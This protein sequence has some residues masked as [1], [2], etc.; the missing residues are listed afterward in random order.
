VKLLSFARAVAN[1]TCFQSLLLSLFLRICKAGNW[2]G[3]VAVVILSDDRDAG[4][5]LALS[6][7]V[8]MCLF[9]IHHAVLI[10]APKND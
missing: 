6:V 10:D 3:L 8:A 1:Y 4:V 7:N 2:V 9:G 5:E